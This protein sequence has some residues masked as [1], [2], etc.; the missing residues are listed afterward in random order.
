MAMA[1]NV[2]LSI[3]LSQIF[4]A[5][6]WMPHVGLALANSLATFIETGWLLWLLRGRLDVIEGRWLMAGVLQSGLATAG[7]GVGIWLW[8]TLWPGDSALW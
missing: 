1:L 5:L 8:T 6:G 7:M 2:V 4:A 3:G